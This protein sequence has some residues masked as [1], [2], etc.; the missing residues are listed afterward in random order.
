MVLVFVKTTNQGPIYLHAR[1]LN[2]WINFKLL[3][4]IQNN[5]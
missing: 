1:R 3:K 4:V 2:S 5:I